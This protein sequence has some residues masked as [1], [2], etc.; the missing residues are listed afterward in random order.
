VGDG[1]TGEKKSKITNIKA[2]TLAERKQVIV[3]HGRPSGRRGIE[4]ARTIRR[5]LE[6]ETSEKG[7][8]ARGTI[9]ETLDVDG[10]KRE[11]KKTSSPRKR[12]K[13]KLRGKN[14]QVW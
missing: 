5:M 8:G 14:M 9:W 13:R 7:K 2:K 12:G 3:G 4:T 6:Q 1:E 11:K 10:R